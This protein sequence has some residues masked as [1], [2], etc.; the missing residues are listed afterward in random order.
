MEKDFLK[1]VDSL[2]DNN[3]EIISRLAEE[4]KLLENLF[5]DNRIPEELKKELLSPYNAMA[6]V[7]EKR[8]DIFHALKEAKTIPNL[9]GFLYNEAQQKYMRSMIKNLQGLSKRRNIK[10]ICFTLKNINLDDGIVEGLVI[11]DE[12][13]TYSS[14]SIPEFIFNI[15][16]YSKAENINK[17]KQLN[18]LYNSMVVNPVNT[19][20]QAVVLD[21]LSS[22]QAVKKYI[23]PASTLTPSIILE[24][25]SN[26][27]TVFLLPERGAH[28]NNSIK[29]E[30]DAKNKSG[31]CSI[32]SG[33]TLQYCDEKKLF[34]TIKKMIKSKKYLVVQ[35]K[36]TLA[37]NGAPLEARVYIQR[38]ITGK[39]SI[40][41]MIAKNERFLKNSIYKDTVDELEKSLLNVIPD[42]VESIIKTLENVSLNTC[43]YLDYYFSNLGSCTLDF[44]IDT[45]G[46]PYIIGLGGWDQKEFLFKLNGKHLWDKYITK[47]IDYLVYLKH[48]RNQGSLYDMG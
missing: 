5:L 16:F 12:A 26:S 13:A 11:D 21:I 24:Y 17:V 9:V 47:S 29:I 31:L 37:W 22:L 41:E 39:W 1:E 23:L 38:G 48:A 40:T 10:I 28:I 42:K 35:G 32:E 7:L 44:I 27:N 8:V 15:G 34:F 30:R 43:S 19:F 2:F 18:S 14:V 25:L 45:N 3:K 4:K 46:D 33:G 6:E 36:K 20:N